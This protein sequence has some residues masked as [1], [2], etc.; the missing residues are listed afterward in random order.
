MKVKCR[1]QKLSF[2]V[3]VKECRKRLALLE[4]QTTAIN[5][6]TKF[7]EDHFV[8]IVGFMSEML[9]LCCTR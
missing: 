5:Q 1:S 6:E 4:F 7:S 8:R 2:L 9:A 3:A